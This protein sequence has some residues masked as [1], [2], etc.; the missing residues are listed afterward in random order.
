LNWSTWTWNEVGM[1]SREA[2]RG[3]FR[4]PWANLCN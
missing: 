3:V 1:K 4:H 2:V